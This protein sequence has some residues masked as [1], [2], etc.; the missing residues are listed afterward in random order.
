MT[1]TCGLYSW[2]ADKILR[3][4]CVMLPHHCKYCHLTF[5]T[6]QGLH[7]HL[8]TQESCRLAH[9]ESLTHQDLRCYDPHDPEALFCEDDP[10]LGWEEEALGATCDDFAHELPNMGPK[11]VR[12][13]GGMSGV[14]VE[15]VEDVDQ[16][17]YPPDIYMEVYPTEAGM[18]KGLVPTCFENLQ[19]TQQEKRHLPYHPFPTLEEWKLA[20]NLLNS[21]AKVNLLLKLPMV[22]VCPHT[23]HM[24]HL[25]NVL[26]IQ[27]T[28]HPNALFHTSHTLLQLISRFLQARLQMCEH[29]GPREHT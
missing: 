5:R 8:S 27:M 17:C 2:R 10:P 15:D 12:E 6:Q 19:C 13:P 26:L 18:P 9:Q 23:S 25:P 29:Q 24:H 22:S 20:E 1:S 3:G 11:A 21:K 4:V 28:N 16:P 14:T 7:A